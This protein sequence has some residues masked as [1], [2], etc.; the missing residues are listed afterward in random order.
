[1]AGR[2]A[3]ALRAASIAVVLSFALLT[4]AQA[5]ES[6]TSQTSPEPE[7][8]QSPSPTSQD[9]FEP[10]LKGT[11]DPYMW[12]FRARESVL[13]I[14]VVGS[15]VLV[16][17]HYGVTG[18]PLDCAHRG[19]TCL[20]TW[21][22]PAGTVRGQ[23]IYVTNEESLGAYPFP[24]RGSCQP[25]WVD[26]SP[27]AFAGWD[28]DPYGP[29]MLSE[30]LIRHRVIY[31]AAREPLDSAH[32]AYYPG[33][34]VAYPTHCPSGSCSPLWKGEKQFGINEPCLRDGI[35]YAAS[36][37]G[38]YTY[39]VGCR[40]N[41]GTCAPL[42]HAA[43]GFGPRG[44]TGGQML[45]GSPRISGGLVFVNTAHDSGG[46]EGGPAQ[47]FAYPTSCGTAD[48][49]CQPVLRYRLKSWF[50]RQLAVVGHRVVLNQGGSLAGATREVPINCAGCPRR[51][52]LIVG[53]SRLGP[54]VGVQG[55]IVTEEGTPGRIH[56]LYDFPSRCG[57]WISCRGV[58][59]WEVDG[60]PHLAGGRLWVTSAEAIYSMP[61][62]RVSS[63]PFAPTWSWHGLDGFRGPN[64]WQQLAV[65]SGVVLVSKGRWVVAI[66]LP[67]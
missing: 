52:R 42:W 12:S 36:A 61:T 40:S 31:V 4:A 53:S 65:A 46:G 32:P 2:R 39:P 67:A 33:R 60:M 45:M 21:D 35:I 5:S 41:G 15:S 56:L 17:D 19:G 3:R 55:H 13:E 24:C 50:P 9:A 10:P 1:M 25:L 37:S 6:S 8:S 16:T 66:R 48:S 64:S 14:K 59:T 43:A 30:P 29:T 11:T 38:L 18:M 23:R 26:R 34:I 47:F 54:F 44:S 28:Q 51:E 49:I 58:Q 22:V 7:S 57:E 20:R 62:H 63:G 27:P